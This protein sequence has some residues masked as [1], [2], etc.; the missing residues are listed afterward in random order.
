MFERNSLP[1]GLLLGLLFPLAGFLGFWLLR[2]Q[3]DGVF[4]LRDRT[5]TLLVICLNLI[6]FRQ[7]NRRR[8]INSL[9]G[10]VTMTVLMAVVWVIRFFS[11]LTT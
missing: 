8:K 4:P 1:W 5:W 11:E 7:F 3:W 10:V 9:R 2:V 6:P